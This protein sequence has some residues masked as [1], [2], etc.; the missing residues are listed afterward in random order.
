MKIRLY[1]YGELVLF[2]YSSTYLSI[3]MLQFPINHTSLLV[4][5]SS[6]IHRPPYVFLMKVNKTGRLRTQTS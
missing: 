1:L 3:S 5:F 4:L 2:A 6:Y